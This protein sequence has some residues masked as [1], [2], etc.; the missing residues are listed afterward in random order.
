MTPTKVSGPTPFVKNPAPGD[1][2]PA[3]DRIA[4]TLS[5]GTNQPIAEEGVADPHQGG[6]S[7]YE[8]G[9]APQNLAVHPVD[10]SFLFR[11]PQLSDEPPQARSIINGFIANVITYPDEAVEWPVSDGISL[12]YDPFIFSPDGKNRG[13]VWPLTMVV[14]GEGVDLTRADSGLLPLIVQA[15]V[16][17]RIFSEELTRKKISEEEWDNFPYKINVHISSAVLHAI[18]ELFYR[19]WDS[20]TLTSLFLHQ[21]FSEARLGE[22][23]SW[24]DSESRL[25]VLLENMAPLIEWIVKMSEMSHKI[26]SLLTDNAENDEAMDVTQLL[27][28][29]N[30]PNTY[31]LGVYDLWRNAI[32]EGRSFDIH[33]LIPARRLDLLV[34]H[35]LALFKSKN[36]EVFI[37]TVVDVSPEL[38]GYFF[39]HRADGNF[40]GRIMENLVSNSVKYHDPKKDYRFIRV[41]VRRF[42]DSLIVGVVDNGSGMSPKFARKRYGLSGQ[43]ELR[44]DLKGV[45]GSGIGAGSALRRIKLMGGEL[46]SLKTAVGK[47]TSIHFS[48]PF[49]L[50]DRVETEDSPVVLTSNGNPTPPPDD[51]IEGGSAEE[52]VNVADDANSAEREPDEETAPLNEK[53]GIPSFGRELSSFGLRG[54]AAVRPPRLSFLVRRF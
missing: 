16:I 41:S 51:L 52:I 20:I 13:K 35:V 29:F 49:S 37:D 5:A 38:T 36:E 18:E 27:H 45:P 6:L 22:G 19:F 32:E 28:D 46:L 21:K 54:T 4:E 26:A 24:P 33:G 3:D 1:E 8:A 42:G 48:T 31:M 44:E 9:E 2:K 40:F 10:T 30:N 7:L 53:P 39:R 11:H 12:A 17:R 43:R 34:A 47:G 15:N 14:S 25:K 50:I 23:E